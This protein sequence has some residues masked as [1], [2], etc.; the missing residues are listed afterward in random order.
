MRVRHGLANLRNQVVHIVAYLRL[1][2]FHGGIGLW[3]LE[4]GAPFGVL[5]QMDDGL[6]GE[7]LGDLRRERFHERVR[8]HDD[9]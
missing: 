1:G 9:G 3:R 7:G 2:D 4:L 6:C 5:A 8:K